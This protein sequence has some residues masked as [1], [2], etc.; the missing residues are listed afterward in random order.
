MDYSQTLNLP[1]T[2]F[3]MKANLSQKEPEIIKEWEKINLYEKLLQNNQ[4]KD[5][6]ILH[7]GPPYANGDIHAGTALNKILKD[8]V[9]KYKTMSGHFS[10]YV[11]GWDCHGQ[12]IEHEVEKKLGSK[13]AKI[14]QQVLREECRNYALKFV[15]RQANQFKRLGVVGDFKHPYLTL[16]HF[17]E[18][19]NVRIFKELYLAG[20]VYKGR[21]PIHWCSNC[22]T[23]LAE[24]EIEYAD[25]KSD[26]IY[27]KFQLEKTPPFLADYN[28]PAHLIVWTTT[29]WT[30]PANV[31]VAL[32]P[33]A[34]YVAV[35]I[36]NEIYVLAQELL[37]QFLSEVSLGDYKLL[38]EFK[39]EALFDYLC[40]HPL[41][42]YKSRVVLSSD[43]VTMDQGTGC[44]HIAPGHGQEDYLIG[45]EYD[46]PAPMPVNDEGVFT[47]EAGRFSGKH[48]S[49]ANPL[50]IDYLKDN[51]LLLK[52]S[53]IT[54]SYPHCWRCKKPVIF[55]STDQWF[56]SM[57]KGD[58]RK[59]TLKIVD[60]VRWIPAW[61]KRRISSMIETRPDWCISRQRAWGVPIPIFYC[62]ECGQV[63]ASCEIFEAVEELFLQSGADAWFVKKSEE[64]L[65]E[66]TAC[67][68][69][70]SKKFRKETDILDVWFESGISHEAVLKT[71]KELAWPAD[72]YLEGSDQHR[73]WFQTSLLASVG[74]NKK[75]PYKAVLTHGFVV[76][77]EGRKMSKSLGN[78]V[79]PLEVIATSGADIL[80][81]WAS[82]TDYA[83]DIAISGEILQ[84]SKEAY[85]RIRNT[86]RF[87]L[88][89]LADFNPAKDRVAYDELEEIDKWALLQLQHLIDYTTGN[90]RRYRFHLVFQ[91][92]YN[93]CVVKMSAFYLD[94]L[95][96]RLYTFKSDS[97]ACRSAQTVLFEL[98]LNLVKII[99]PLLTFT[100]EE[101]YKFVP[102]RDK[103]SVLL[104]SWPKA[105]KEHFNDELEKKWEELLVIRGEVLKVLEDARV[106]KT[107]GN[108]LEA[109]VTLYFDSKLSSFLSDYQNLLPTIFIVSQVKMAGIKEAPK[110][111][112][113][114]KQLKGLKILTK[115]ADGNKCSRCWNYNLSVGK[116]SQHPTLCKR[117]IETI[118]V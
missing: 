73:G 30:L 71:R 107:I 115:K 12:P 78:V 61:S 51:N 105:E 97:K 91:A 84:R 76:D 102:G 99:S 114:S 68:K 21:K 94:V 98:L 80:R 106:A 86:F 72:L 47:D 69:C 4:G 16:E 27:V 45:L 112:Y 118:S 75:S 7:D 100:A 15:D 62:S 28:L 117:C 32:H 83:S 2:D 44:V 60:E 87:L 88:G 40:K 53:Y 89:N 39:G 101:V 113:Q 46:L 9:V 6:F 18:A 48:I 25:E 11:P 108:S 70:K 26:S 13:R 54:H 90:Y 109:Q 1:K 67:P 14:S 103:E 3:P 92:V 36:E 74:A 33:T 77:G 82:A 110:D 43:F 104:C 111:A 52:S 42:G 10:P 56:I 96:D 55:R 34:K 58:L 22:K 59:E 38:N 20:L 8:I 17:Y 66:G 37:E 23:A 93:F 50:I 5:S 63:L 64:I 81:L 24:A 79:D 65:P 116:N 95:K 85:R 35:K 57:D 41:K 19:T 29:P 31:A 49:E